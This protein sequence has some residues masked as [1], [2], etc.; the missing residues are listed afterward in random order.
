MDGN[1]IPKPVSVPGLWPGTAARV[2]AIV[3]MSHPGIRIMGDTADDDRQHGMGT[4]V[5]YARREGKPQR[6]A[7]KPFH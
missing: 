5:E 2:P 3:E 6:V 1:P 7:A 4:V